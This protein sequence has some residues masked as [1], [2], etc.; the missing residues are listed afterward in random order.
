MLRLALIGVIMTAGVACDTALETPGPPERPELVDLQ[1]LQRPVGSHLIP[2]A[3]GNTWITESFVR[4]ELQSVGTT[5]VGDTLR[6]WPNWDGPA[7]PLNT[8]FVING[9]LVDP[10]D[11]YV[12]GNNG[13]GVSF[14][15]GV[16]PEDTIVVR[17]DTWP[18]PTEVGARSHY[19]HVGYSVSGDWAEAPAT[20]EWTVVSTDSLLYTPLGAFRT[21]VFQREGRYD[22]L[23][24]TKIKRDTHFYAPGIGRIQ[25]QQHRLH[26]PEPWAVTFLN[27]YCLMQEPP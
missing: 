11:S 25:I 19:R 2:L 24:S 14:L 9:V 17:W 12:F 15:G 22:S 18:Y 13:L 5:V 26:E 7:F 8:A 27:E 4:G 1:C 10:E 3:T 20:L 23:D 21:V 6:N 16:A